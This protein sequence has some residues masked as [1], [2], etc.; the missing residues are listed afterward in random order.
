MQNTDLLTVSTPSLIFDP[1]K[2][3]PLA[4][5]FEITNLTDKPVTFKIKFK[6]NNVFYRVKP[7]LGVISPK[8]STTINV[9]LEKADTPIQPTDKHKIRIQGSLIPNNISVDQLKTY[10]LYELSHI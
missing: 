9:S 7:S 5:S 6:A 3:L 8:L 4:S 2:S 1:S 10:V